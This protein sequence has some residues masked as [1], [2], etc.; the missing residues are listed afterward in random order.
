MAYYDSL[1]G[2]GNQ[3]LF[4]EELKQKVDPSTEQEFA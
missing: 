2:L 1:T 3:R 4:N